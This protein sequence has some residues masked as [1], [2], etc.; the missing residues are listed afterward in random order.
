MML[1]Y[2]GLELGVKSEEI[3][4]S[5]ARQ[6]YEMSQMSMKGWADVERGSNDEPQQFSSQL[7]QP[8]RDDTRP[9]RIEKF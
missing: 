9:Q 8:D 2:V 7:G 5:S 1:V 6:P 4:G 3:T